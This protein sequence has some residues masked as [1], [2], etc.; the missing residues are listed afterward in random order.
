MK[1]A[2]Q[3]LKTICFYIII[4]ECWKTVFESGRRM[5][6]RALFIGFSGRSSAAVKMKGERPAQQ[7]NVP[8]CVEEGKENQC[9]EP[10]APSP[11]VS[12]VRRAYPLTPIWQAVHLVSEAKAVEPSWQ[13]PQYLPSYNDS[14]TKSSFS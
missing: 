1:E 11:L 10:S 3:D 12:P 2:Q 4:T 13:A 5:I 7:P 8:L 14:I 6:P 9:P